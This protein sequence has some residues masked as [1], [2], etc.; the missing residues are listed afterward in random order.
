M[1]LLEEAAE[2][3]QSVGELLQDA[4][5]DSDDVF[6]EMTDGDLFVNFGDDEARFAFDDDVLF[7]GGKVEQTALATLGRPMMSACSESA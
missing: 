3:G 1:D 2:T 7:V 6:A 4:I 5:Q